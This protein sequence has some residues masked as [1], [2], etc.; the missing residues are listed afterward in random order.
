MKN[1]I[2]LLGVLLTTITVSGQPHVRQAGYIEKQS[3]WVETKDLPLANNKLPVSNPNRRQQAETI[4]ERIYDYG[5]YNK[6]GEI[7]IDYA[8]FIANGRF[9]MLSYE[10]LDDRIATD[11]PEHLK[12]QGTLEAELYLYS[13]DLSAPKSDW[14]IASVEKIRD[15]SADEITYY[16]IPSNL[17]VCRSTFYNCYYEDVDF[18]MYD[19]DNV[20]SGR[21]TKHNDG[22]VE[23]TA[24]F[25][26]FENGK[27]TYVD[28]KLITFVLTP[29]DKKHYTYEIK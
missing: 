20:K 28:D 16:Y 1:I 13:I 2:T 6:K 4:G 27:R 15:Y 17:L 9:F 23:I 21:V 8:H 19:N 26:V 10:D 14:E 22:T 24:D 11:L 3:H 25:Y 5:F 12:N 29:I 7:W 18:Y